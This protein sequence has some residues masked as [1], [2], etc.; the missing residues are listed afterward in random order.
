MKTIA[1]TNH[2][3]GV[4]KSGL[5]V[6]LAGALQ[7]HRRRQS[8]G[9]GADD[10]HVARGGNLA[11]AGKFDTGKMSGIPLISLRT[12]MVQHTLQAFPLF[13]RHLWRITPCSR[14]HVSCGA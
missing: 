12:S 14:V 10:G 8:G 5:A 4:G 13:G 1:I 3:G 11:H 9:A 7:E 6:C 2:K